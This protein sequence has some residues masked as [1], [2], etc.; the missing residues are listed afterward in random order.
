MSRGNVVL[1]GVAAGIVALPLLMPASGGFKGSDDQGS[2]AISALSP[3]YQPWFTPL[4][5]PPSGEVESLLFSL[6][7]AAGA[8]LLGYYLGFRRGRRKRSEDEPRAGD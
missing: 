5:S 1:L 7:A 2:A 3:G 8:G 4:W 6:Q